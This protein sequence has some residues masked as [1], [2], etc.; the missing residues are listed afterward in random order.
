[1]EDVPVQEQFEL[2]LVDQFENK[3]NACDYDRL[4]YDCTMLVPLRRTAEALN[5]LFLR[6]FCIS[7]SQI[8]H[9]RDRGDLVLDGASAYASF[10]CETNLE[11]SCPYRTHSLWRY[12]KRRA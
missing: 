7:E 8:R 2:C 9:D 6:R 10:K 12:I 11:P 5:Q 1:M 4:N 3:N